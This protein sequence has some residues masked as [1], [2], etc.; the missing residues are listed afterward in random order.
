MEDEE[1]RLILP[2][3]F[4]PAAERYNLVEQLDRW[5]IARAAALLAEHPAFL[6]RIDFVSL[7]LSGQSLTQDG[8][9]DFI[10]ST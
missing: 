8:F 10:I 1:G 3:A 9:L 7:N 5:A 6:N 2:A 4:L